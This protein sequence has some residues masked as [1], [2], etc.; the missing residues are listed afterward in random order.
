MLGPGACSGTNHNA[1]FCS[2]QWYKSN[3]RVD[4]GSKTRLNEASSAEQCVAGWLHVSSSVLQW[5]V[6]MACCSS[7]LQQ[8]VAVTVLQSLCCSSVYHTLDTKY[9]VDMS[10]RVLQW[11]V[12]VSVLQSVYC[13]QCAAVSVLQQYVAVCVLQSVCCRSVLQQIVAV[14]ALQQCVPYTV[15]TTYVFDMPYICCSNVL[16]SV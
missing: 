15:D 2:K 14:R 1:P 5:C 8:C 7:V 10:S 11:C 4:K 12:A 6:A 9:W 16:Q 3:K 13:G